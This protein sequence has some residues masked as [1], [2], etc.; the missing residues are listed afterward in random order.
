M[1]TGGD[2]QMPAAGPCGRIVTY[3]SLR[4]R[5]AELR[6][7]E[8]HAALEVAELAD[9]T[10]AELER[11]ERAFL[12]ATAA[13]DA[14]RSL[15]SRVETAAPSLPGERRGPFRGRPDD[16]ASDGEVC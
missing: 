13:Y 1:S 12:Q 3:V 10:P 9:A 2:V 11:L 8:A 5:S 16:E 14:A 15:S 4:A 6:M 7:R